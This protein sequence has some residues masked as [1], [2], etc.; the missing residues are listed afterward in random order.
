M[1]LESTCAL[2]QVEG[3]TFR[4]FR[5][6]QDYAPMTA[7]QNLMNRVYGVEEV[8]SVEETAH[9]YEHR[10]ADQDLSRDMLLAEANG[11]LVGYANV[12]SQLRGDGNRRD[13]ASRLAGANGTSAIAVQRTSRARDRRRTANGRA[14]LS[15]P[16]AV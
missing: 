16:M 6:E 12:V 9:G 8:L 5:G 1:T 4:Q 14:A 13:C 2:P 3:I 10:D 11:Q 7:L 15:E